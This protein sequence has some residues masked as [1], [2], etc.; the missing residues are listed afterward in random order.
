MKQRLI[1]AGQEQNLSLAHPGDLTRSLQ[2]SILRLA[3]I[4]LMFHPRL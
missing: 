2:N 3:S 1:A 4:R